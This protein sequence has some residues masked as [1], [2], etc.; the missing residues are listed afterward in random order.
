MK[1]ME[2]NLY[3][4]GKFKNYNIR[5][6]PGLNL[7]Y[8]QNESGKSTLHSF[9]NGMFYGFVKPYSKR[10]IYTNDHKKFSPWSSGNYSGSILFENN[11]EVYR[12][13]RTFTKGNEETKVFIE[14]TGEDITKNIE[15][16]DSSRVLQPGEYFFGINSSV[17]NNTLFIGQKKIKPDQN[18]ADEVREI[19]VNVSTGGDENI[20]VEKALKHL[21]NQ[22]KEIGTSRASTTEY[23]KTKDLINDAKAKLQSVSKDVLKYK[24]YMVA[25]RELKREFK[26][27]KKKLNQKKEILESIKVQEK[28]DAY[29]EVIELREKNRILGEELEDLFAYKDNKPEDLY[30]ANKLHEE[31]VIMESS[32]GFLN[33]QLDEIKKKEEKT[34]NNQL[35]N[36]DNLETIIK[37]GYRFER[38]DT[39]NQELNDLDTLEQKMGISKKNKNKFTISAF[40]L[41]IVYFVLSGYI[42]LDRNYI[43][44]VFIQLLLIGII[45]GIVKSSNISNEIKDIH[46]EIEVEK[47]KNSILE[48]YKKENRQDFYKTFE[49]AKTCKT[50]IDQD[51]AKSL[52]TNESKN[53]LISKI[54]D[55]NEEV[56]TSQDKLKDILAANNVED[57]TLLRE[58][59]KKKARF[60]EIK[61]EMEYNQGMIQKISKDEKMDK[62]EKSYINKLEVQNGNNKFNKNHVV[63]SILEL[64]NTSNSIQMKFNEVTGS[65]TQLEEFIE[66]EIMLKEKIGSLENKKKILKD[67]KQSLEIA[68]ERIINL[69]AKIH[70]EYSSSINDRI[71]D[72]IANITG[73]KYSGVKV[74][75]NLDLGLVE[76]LSG[77]I[78]PVDYLSGGTLDQLYFGLRLTIL[79]ELVS[80]KLP[81]F[82]DETFSK[83]DDIRLENMIK[84]ITDNRERQ[85]V[86]FSSHK[87]EEKTLEKMEKKYN[88]IYL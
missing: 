14:A 24:E 82:L 23:G 71:G 84:Y 66:Q 76:S 57:I 79:D 28:L 12:I 8:G 5:L 67:T 52:E 16:L 3:G 63:E 19:L 54:K 69:S 72:L 6:D 49:N 34:Y 35:D 4:F 36:S 42:F 33:E 40:I 46:K 70:R 78:V 21:D 47:E 15:E 31:I 27:V 18:L 73:K 81:I 55:L 48:K 44:G 30:R 51:K 86:I 7:I 85:I 53:T 87:R 37:D 10:T 74:D 56:S 2:L 22:L 9:I 65:L 41:G 20:S 11:G 64:E 25:H 38:L 29:K 43:L 88:K 1:I 58:G 83:Y 17:F 26:V 59:L 45:Y 60:S 80:S 61:R 68:R 50:K 13:Q 32:V 75:K 39:L 77:R 62:L